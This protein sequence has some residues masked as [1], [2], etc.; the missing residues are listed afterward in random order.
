MVMRSR[1]R[2]VQQ[3]GNEKQKEKGMVMVTGFPFNERG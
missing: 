1:R 3:Y 2:R